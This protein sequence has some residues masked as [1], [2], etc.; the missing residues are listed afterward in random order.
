MIIPHAFYISDGSSDSP[1]SSSTTNQQGRVKVM[2]VEQSALLCQL[3][4]PNSR[5]SVLSPSYCCKNDLHE[6]GF[7]GGNVTL[8]PLRCSIQNSS[9]CVGIY[10]SRNLRCLLTFSFFCFLLLFF[11]QQK[12]IE[13]PDNRTDTQWGAHTHSGLLQYRVRGTCRIH[14]VGPCFQC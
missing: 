4:S 14:L 12:T 7:G 6:Q 8:Y 11:L 13:L 5:S 2:T 1:S 3:S 10:D 9:R